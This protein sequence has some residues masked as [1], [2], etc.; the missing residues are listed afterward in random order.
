MTKDTDPPRCVA[1]GASS[2]QSEP[3]GCF[4]A[5]SLVS[6]A[7]DAYVRAYDASER[8]CPY[9][10]EDARPC[11]WCPY[12]HRSAPRSGTH[13]RTRRRAPAKDVSNS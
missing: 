5:S 13:P 6:H 2:G 10:C 12:A 3:S 7:Y 11:R 9:V 8:D 4:V 1:P